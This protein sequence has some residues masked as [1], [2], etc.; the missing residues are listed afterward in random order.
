MMAKDEF[1]LW[2]FGD[3][4]VGSDLK[5]GRKSLAYALRTSE[6]G[7]AEGGTPFHWDIAVDVG[8]MSGGQGLPDDEEGKEVV[9][10]LSVLK[11]HRREDIY[12]VCGNHDRSGLGEPPAWWWRK[13]ID[14][15]GRNRA[16][17]GVNPHK[18]PSPVE[19]TWER[20]SFCVGNVLFLMM[21]DINE[22]SQTLGRGDLGGN[23]AGVVSGATFRWWK[24]MV[25]RH[26][27]CII[28]TV[29]HYV[30]KDTTVASG[31]WEGMRS[32]GDGKWRGH[33]HGYKPEGAPRGAS[34]LYFVDSVPD[35]G[36][37]ESFLND[38]PGEVDL[39]FGG[40]THT[41]PDDQYGGK[42]HVETRWGTHFINAACLTRYH[43]PETSVPKSRI[44]TFTEGSDQVQVD[45]YLHSGEFMPEG[46][47]ERA[48]RTLRLSQP[49]HSAPTGAPVECPENHAAKQGIENPETPNKT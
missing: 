49:F 5:F 8:D 23:P 19:G 37:F 43:V 9:Q 7:G 44:L 16:F 48:S 39:W 34:Y 32:E 46:W 28:I 24:E 20:Y 10:Q 6:Q 2:V 26:P 40:H 45:C 35:S 30:L 1:R 47:Y 18:R 12:S 36:S 15:M 33:Y 14:P 25:E 13:W 29:H 4:H 41:H 42:S 38:H 21:S 22:P 27:E 31:D 3:A 17:S 11:K